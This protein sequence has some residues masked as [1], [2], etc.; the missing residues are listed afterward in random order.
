MLDILSEPFVAHFFGGEEV[1]V[2]SGI[3]QALEEFTTAGTGFFGVVLD[4]DL[5]VAGQL[6]AEE[7]GLDGEDHALNKYDIG[8]EA[9]GDFV[10]APGGREDVGVVCGGVAAGIG[11]DVADVIDGYV[12]GVVDAVDADDGVFFGE[13]FEQAGVS[14]YAMQPCCRVG[15][16]SFTSIGD[17]YKFHGIKVAIFNSSIAV[18]DKE[19]FECGA[20]SS[21]GGADG[22]EGILYG[23]YW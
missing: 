1:G 11:E 2:D 23:G 15:V 21:A 4:D 20:A 14:A 3:G 13:G 6:D 22:G 10:E 19:S 8:V 9:A 16:L 18:Y 5:C 17:A 12:A 7:D